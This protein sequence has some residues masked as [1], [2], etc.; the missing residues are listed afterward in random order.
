MGLK[1][2]RGLRGESLT[3]IFVTPSASNNIRYVDTYQSSDFSVPQTDVPPEVVVAYRNDEK[4]GPHITRSVNG[5]LVRA[6]S[7]RRY[8][9]GQW[10]AR[11]DVP[12][13]LRL[14]GINRVRFAPTQQDD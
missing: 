14:S 3:G 7:V 9:D 10:H 12:Y 2:A 6:A 5:R 8:D 4:P 11:A 13:D 1:V